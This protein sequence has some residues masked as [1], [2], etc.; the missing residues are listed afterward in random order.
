MLSSDTQRVAWTLASASKIY[1]TSSKSSEFSE[2]APKQS[3]AVERPGRAAEE[4]S[5]L[6]GLAD[7]QKS[8]VATQ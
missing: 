2:P 7:A 6:R 3:Q 8:G 5:W 1:E 4:T